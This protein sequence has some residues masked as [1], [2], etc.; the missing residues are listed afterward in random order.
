MSVLHWFDAQLWK[1]RLQSCISLSSRRSAKIYPFS[2]EELYFQLLRQAKL[3]TPG[4]FYA[5]LKEIYQCYIQN[6]PSFSIKLDELISGGWLDCFCDRWAIVG[7][8]RES[9]SNDSQDARVQAAVEFLLWLQTQVPPRT[10]CSVFERLGY[11]FVRNTPP[12]PG[13]P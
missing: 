10:Q 3:E 8:L 9:H 7:H 4:D 5:K 2:I 1:Q 12:L 13:S 6:H 11:R